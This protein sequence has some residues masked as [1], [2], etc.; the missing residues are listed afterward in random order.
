MHIGGPLKGLWK[1]IRGILE[2]PCRHPRNRP[3]LYITN[4]RK[5]IIFIPHNY[6]SAHA[7]LPTHAILNT[8]HRKRYSTR[9]HCLLIHTP[10]LRTLLTTLSSTF[11]PLSPHTHAHTHYAL[12]HTHHFLHTLLTTLPLSLTLPPHHH[13]PPLLPQ[14]ID[15]IMWTGDSVPHDLWKITRRGNRAVLSQVADMIHQYFPGTPVYG[16]IGNHESF[17]RDR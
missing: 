11:Y 3:R 2:T 10:L 15:Y 5:Q 9:I 16:S 6:Y 4:T 1:H 7:T 13:H 17:P 8:P 14:D 12:I